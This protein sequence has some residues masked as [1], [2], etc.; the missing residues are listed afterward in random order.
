MF[1]SAVDAWGSLPTINGSSLLQRPSPQPT[2]T[3]NNNMKQF[4]IGWLR[5][6]AVSWIIGSSKN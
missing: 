1:L 6:R 4:E 5:C 3:M 2:T